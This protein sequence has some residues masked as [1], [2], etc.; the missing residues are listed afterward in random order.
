ML[1]EMRNTLSPQAV[2]LARLRALVDTQR[3]VPFKRRYLNLI[4]QSNLRKGDKNDAMKV[5][6]VALE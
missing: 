3:G 6:T 5:I 1:V 2:L 4:A